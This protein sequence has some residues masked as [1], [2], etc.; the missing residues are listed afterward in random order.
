M[1]AQ[2]NSSFPAQNSTFDFCVTPPWAM[3][4]A[5]GTI[6]YNNNPTS[7]ER[8]YFVDN[9]S[10]SNSTQYIDLYLLNTTYGT[11]TTITFVTPSGTPLK[12]HQVIV[13]RY[14]PAISQYI[15]VA[16]GITGSDGTVPMFLALYSTWYKFVVYE[17]GSVYYMTTPMMLSSTTI[18][19]TVNPSANLFAYWNTAG[20]V[21]GSCITINT[22]S[23]YTESCT[24]ADSSGLVQS[25]TLLVKQLV[26]GT[27][28]ETC[29]NTV[30]ASVGT[31]ICNIGNNTAN[32]LYWYSFSYAA[33]PPVTLLSNFLNFLNTVVAYGNMGLFLTAMIVLTM[34]LVGLW[35]PAVSIVLGI[36]GLFVSYG[37]GLMPPGALSA[38]IY[39]T[40]AG[41]IVIWLLR[42]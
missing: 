42:S 13:Q 39:V 19:V 26:G 14:Y 23:N 30:N 29:S 27:W 20:S 11:Q 40:M 6:G 5:T 7:P 38:L 17:G 12:D 15:S 24:G 41:M 10:I 1:T 31:A 32:K 8:Y 25:Y 33:S 34:I 3:F 36:V 28:I 4:N 37:L 18:T 22:S 16:A 35:H 9:L 2:Y 21:S